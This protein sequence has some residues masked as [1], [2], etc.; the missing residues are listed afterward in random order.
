MEVQSGGVA[1]ER[2]DIKVLLGHESIATTQIYTN[3]GQ[4]GTGAG[5]GGGKV[6][7]AELGYVRLG[8]FEC[9]VLGT[10]WR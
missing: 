5:S 1:A 4:C 10:M 9:F 2:V 3:V 6:V 8:E 7:S